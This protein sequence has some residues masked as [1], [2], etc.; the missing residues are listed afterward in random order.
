MIQ[1][2][3]K[4]LII[5]KIKERLAGLLNYNLSDISDD[6]NLADYGID[7]IIALQL[8]EPFKSEV[9]AISPT[10]LLQSKNMHM[11]ADHLMVLMQRRDSQQEHS[12]GFI[13]VDYDHI[14]FQE[15][16][17]TQQIHNGMEW[18]IFGNRTHK[19]IILLSPLNTLSHIW[20][21]QIRF[22]L[23]QNQYVLYIP[24]YPGHSQSIYQA[25]PLEEIAQ[26]I[27]KGFEEITHNCINFD[28]IGWSIGGCLSMLMSHI[29]PNKIKKNSTH[30]YGC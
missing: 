30:Q 18:F 24:S 15:L 14:L 19:P 28:I 11:I 16:P 3:K 13:N 8:L 4:K 25:Y 7:S 20:I 6:R 29:E 1:Q 26:N 17:G 22:F 9:G 2:N 27:I 12:K 21:Q 10:I 23:K 5:N